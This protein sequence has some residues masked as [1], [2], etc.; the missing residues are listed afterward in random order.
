VVVVPP[1]EEDET[2]EDD[3]I[4]DE[5]DV[6][7][8][9]P[10]DDDPADEDEP[11]TDRCGRAAVKCANLAPMTAAAATERRP[12]R[13]VIFLTRRRPSSR[14]RA[15]LEYWVRVTPSGSPVI[16]CD[17][18]DVLLRKV[19]IAIAPVTVD[20]ASAA[21]WS[22]AA[23]HC[24]EVGARDRYRELLFIRQPTAGSGARRVTAAI[25][26]AWPRPHA[27]RSS[28]RPAA[29]RA[30]ARIRVREGTPRRAVRRRA[31]H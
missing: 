26:G 14:A 13:Q 27:G 21:A 7:A 12:I 28:W 9:V 8:E 22:R 24:D 25:V 29:S 4:P 17:G 6:P 19:R 15:A 10:V 3:E 16:L 2:P 30:W 1:P 18:T 11:S 31:R 5:E 23:G 20:M